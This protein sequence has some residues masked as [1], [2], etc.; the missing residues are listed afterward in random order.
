MK[1]KPYPTALTNNEWKIIEPLIPAAKPGGH[2]RT[3]DIRSRSQCYLL[4]H[5]QWLSL[6]DAAS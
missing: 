2:P 6:L 3:V 1:R 5:S 4:C